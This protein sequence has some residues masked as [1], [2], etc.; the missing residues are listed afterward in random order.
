MNASH[1]SL[2]GNLP[3]IGLTMG[4]PAGIGPELCLTLLRDE[5]VFTR[6]RPVIF[7]D[8]KLLQR[9]ATTCGTPLAPPGEGDVVEVACADMETIVPGRISAAGGRAAYRCVEAATR[10]ALAK[11]IAAIVTAPLNKESLH[12]AG[13]PFPGHTEMLAD[14]TGTR[15][16]CM[17]LASD[18]IVTSLVTTHTALSQVPAGLS[19][20]RILE[21]I[22]LTHAA[23]SRLRPGRPRL[24]VCALNPHAGENG[25]FGAEEETLI[26]PAILQARQE[27]LQIEGPL[28]PDTAFLPDRLARTDATICMYH[29]QGLIPFK[30][31]AFDVGVN[32]TLGLPIVRTSPDHGTAFDLAWTGRAHASSM[33]EAILLAARLCR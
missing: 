33:R 9:I 20:E 29:D 27:G 13:V 17:M 8:T 10:E 3:V 19:V 22:R 26:L 28:P 2:D 32:V 11:R 16:Y 7:G 15:R 30:M 6:C 4:D 5:E 12:L 23:M 25:L 14:L 24:T 21:V 1:K 31:L 18:K